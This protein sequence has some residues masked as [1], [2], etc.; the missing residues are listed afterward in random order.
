MVRGGSTEQVTFEIRFEI[1]KHESLKYLE[2]EDSRQGDSL[3]K[4]PEAG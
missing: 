2:E 1:S 4:S 3:Y